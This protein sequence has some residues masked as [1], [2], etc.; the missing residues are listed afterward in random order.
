MN[1]YNHAPA[2]LPSEPI[3]CFRTKIFSC[4]CIFS[5]FQST[6]PQFSPRLNVDRKI[7]PG[8]GFSQSPSVF[9]CQFIPP[10]SHDHPD[11]STAQLIQG[12]SRLYGITAGGDFLGFCDQ[13]RF[14]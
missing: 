2:A 14:I 6:I 13:K 8:T 4:N 10:K 1:I 11:A 7:V 9:P 5:S 12:V 3:Q